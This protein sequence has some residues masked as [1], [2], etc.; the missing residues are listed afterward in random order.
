MKVPGPGNYEILYN[1][2]KNSPNYGFG[3]GTRDKGSPTSIKSLS[4]GPG[5]YPIKTK[6]GAEGVKSSIHSKLLYKPI[7]RIGG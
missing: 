1:D 5:N 6:V 7:E 2:K 3:S 4:P